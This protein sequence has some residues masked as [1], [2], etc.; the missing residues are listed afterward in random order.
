ML[1][2]VNHVTEDFSIAVRLPSDL[3][4]RF[5]LFPAVGGRALKKITLRI[6]TSFWKGTV[7][8]KNLVVNKRGFFLTDA[9]GS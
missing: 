4:I 2:S 8:A 5:H 1:E 9:V 6:A 3:H 7:A